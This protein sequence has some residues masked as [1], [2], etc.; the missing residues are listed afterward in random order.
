MSKIS[1]TT[2]AGLTSGGDANKVII[3]SGDTLQVDSNATVGGTLGV[4]GVSTLSGNATV[5]G[6]LGVTGATTLSSNLTVDGGTIK[7]DGNFPTA[8]HNVA[9]GNAA[10]SSGSLS[11][12]NNV[13]IGS[14]TLASNTSGA[15]NIG[16]GRNT[17]DSNTDGMHN[18]GIGHAVLTANVSGSGNVGIGRDSLSNNTASH[19]TAVGY[20]SLITNTSGANGT[21]IGMDAL[22][23]NTTGS[24]N[25][26]VGSVALDA[27]TTGTAN[28]ALGR[29]S[30]TTNTTGSQNV[31]IGVSALE[32][33]STGDYNTSVGNNS[34]AAAA[35][36]SSSNT[37]IGYGAGSSITSGSKITT[38]GLFNG[39]QTGLDIRTS[40]KQIVL[41]DGDGTPAARWD[42]P[43][44]QWYFNY[45]VAVSDGNF[46]SR[47]GGGQ[48]SNNNQCGFAFYSCGT[49]NDRTGMYW[50][51][52]GVVNSR[53]WVDNTNDLRIHSG[54]PTAHNSGTVV[55]SQSFTATH[56]YKTDE[57]DLKVGEAVC[58]VGQ[59][60]VRA[61]DEKSKTCVGIYA[62]QS[63]K[64]Q[65]S[66]GNVC[67]D[68]DGWGHAVISL[69]DTRLHQSDVETVGVLVDGSVSA[70]DLL[71]TSSTSG[72]LT[73]QDD[74]IIHSYTVGK[75][76]ES[77]DG[78]SPI[79]AYIYS[80]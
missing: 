63:A 62:G 55:G 59:K 26:A 15:Q 37:A 31:G 60:I 77:G 1:V 80:G 23:L 57:K 76:M 66:M 33:V 49:D 27:N 36:G 18:T 71:C 70:G 25:T 24:N 3:E 28:V 42:G 50:E 6:T 29:A 58:L 32:A 44:N 22:K 12:S 46:H 54:N 53:M 52:Q 78:S 9:L 47:F 16:I 34:L 20:Q 13:A 40:N 21:A 68:T 72:K 19:N 61:T 73:V 51:Q 39:N 14:N 65:D 43:N 30:L 74:D 56:I 8:G 4:T 11:G 10:L 35:T 79:Y 67:N 48:S 38:I 41:S 5:G 75:A 17:L 69:G 7:L 64:I 45:Y 2:I